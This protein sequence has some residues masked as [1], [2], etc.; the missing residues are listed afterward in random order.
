MSKSKALV[1]AYRSEIFVRLSLLVN[2]YPQTS[3]AVLTVLLQN[4]MHPITPCS[5]LDSL[6][7]FQYFTHGVNGFPLGLMVGPC[8]EFAEQP[9]GDELHTHEDK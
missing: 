8:L 5:L 2:G 4:S 6:L 3:K 1:N 7:F 9:H